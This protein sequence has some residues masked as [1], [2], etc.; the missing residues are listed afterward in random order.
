MITSSKCLFQQ[1]GCL[2]YKCFCIIHNYNVHVFIRMIMH[3]PCTY[4]RVLT[5]FF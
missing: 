4:V 2:R 5:M 3:I 1:Y